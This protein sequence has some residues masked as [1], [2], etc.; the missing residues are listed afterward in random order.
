MTCEGIYKIRNFTAVRKKWET[1]VWIVGSATVHF[2][3]HKIKPFDQS[4]PPSFL[5][6]VMEEMNLRDFKQVREAPPPEGIR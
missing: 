6:C 4:M 3:Y 2:L 1:D 5:Q